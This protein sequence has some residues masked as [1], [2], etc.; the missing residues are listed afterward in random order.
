MSDVTPPLK[1]KP[2]WLNELGPVVEGIPA[3][4][5]PEPQCFEGR[6]C[7]LEPLSL[8]NHEDDLW[9]QMAVA[10]PDMRQW[11]F[12]AGLGPFEDQAA[13]A[14]AWR[15][16]A[17]AVDNLTY[18]VIPTDSVCG[19]PEVATGQ[20]SFLRLRPAAGSIEVGFVRFP[21]QMAR[22]R[23]STEAQYL[24]M[25]HVFDD[26]RYRRYEWKCNADNQP[27]MRTA[28]RLGFTYEGTFRQDMINH[29]RNRDTAWWSII[30]S[31]WP[32]LKRAY[33]AWLDPLNFDPEA[34]Q[35]RCL[36]DLIAEYR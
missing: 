15:Q 19:L 1:A 26:L 24:L 12:L 35:R 16:F 6:Y 32:A 33:L 21:P 5:R 13:F 30:D 36:A 7:R 25:A 17:E 20:L 10:D 28:A 34:R 3:W 23:V 4:Q 31:E 22:T 2:D 9:A 8:K 11:M 14:A 29:G 18:V 27:S